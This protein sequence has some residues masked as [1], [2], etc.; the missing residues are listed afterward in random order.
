MKFYPLTFSGSFV[1]QDIKR[2]ETRGH[3]AVTSYPDIPYIV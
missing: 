1:Y 2:P 3:L